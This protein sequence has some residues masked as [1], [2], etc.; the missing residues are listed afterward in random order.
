MAASKSYYARSQRFNICR[1]IK[2]D[3][4]CYS[5][6]H[7]DD[8]RILGE[9]IIEFHIEKETNF[10]VLN[11]RDLN[12]TDKMVTSSKGNSMKIVKFLEY[13]PADQIYFEVK[14]R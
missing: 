10:I 3:I 4:L 9:V 11:A 12:I 1:I 8:F 14:V 6:Y 13:K 7:Q 5:K 2:F